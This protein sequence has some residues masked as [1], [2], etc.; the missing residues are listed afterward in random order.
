MQGGEQVQLIACMTRSGRYVPLAKLRA[1]ALRQEKKRAGSR[2][3]RTCKKKAG[4][5]GSKNSGVSHLIEYDNM[6][7]LHIYLS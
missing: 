2:I 6:V 7:P 1:G 5:Q 4:G 3:M